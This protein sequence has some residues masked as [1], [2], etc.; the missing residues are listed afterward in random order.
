MEDNKYTQ[1]ALSCL[2]REELRRM[3]KEELNKGS[4]QADDSFVRLLLAELQ[5]RGDD[6]KLTSDEAVETACEKFRLAT[7]QAKVPQ[8]RRQRS[9]MVA[10]A[11]V[12]LLLGVLFFTLPGT[13]QAG[14]IRGMLSWWSDSTFRFL[15]PG[16]QIGPQA[17]VY[18]TDRPGLQQV[19][20]AVTEMGITE[21]IV[22]RWVPQGTELYSLDVYQLSLDSSLL[23][24]LKSE[25]G[26]IMFSVIVRNE[27]ASVQYEKD[28]ETVKIWDMSGTEHYVL[29]N[30]VNL[31][32]TWVR[33]NIECSLTTDYP[34]E[35][36][37]RMIKSIYISEG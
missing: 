22:P 12:V 2:P 35:D 4:S 14:D 17:Y 28:K 19:Y 31:A 11:S 3:L 15:N 5:S 16:K 34:E 29:S 6:P 20:D 21:P 1:E 10:V 26:N 7:E 24:C 18:E 23:A 30:N 33:N 25:D 13:A 37:Y 27:Q 9:W 32:V 36:V 8:N